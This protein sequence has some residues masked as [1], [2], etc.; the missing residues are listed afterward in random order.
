MAGVKS[1]FFAYFLQ[2][3]AFSLLRLRLLLLTLMASALVHGQSSEEQDVRSKIDKLRAGA[4]INVKDTVYIDLLNKL[5]KSQRYYNTD[6]LLL[7]SEQAL[8]HSRNASYKSGESYALLNL[9]DY[10]S[11]KGE[12]KKA[13]SNYEES[14]KI[15]KSIN[16]EHQVLRVLN[17]LS[18]EY[19]YM[20]DYA[21]ALNGYLEG[22]ELAQKIGNKRMLSIM[23]EDMP[24][25]TLLKK[26]MNRPWNIIRSLNGSMKKSTKRSILRKPSAIWPRY[27]PIWVNWSMPC[28]TSI[29]VSPPS[30]KKA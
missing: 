15:A 16:N 8:K 10:Y 9:G 29:P 28:S 11:D 4:G 20:G 3:V 5:A 6:S 17:N 13:I 21:N 1:R 18:G 26:T 2:T 30:K 22:V 19:G 23:N 14:L 25:F 24:V 12:F 27:M 7:V